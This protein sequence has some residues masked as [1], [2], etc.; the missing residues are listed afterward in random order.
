[1]S[2]G[3]SADFLEGHVGVKLQH[4]YGKGGAIFLTVHEGTQC[5]EVFRIPPC[6]L[7]GK[8]VQGSR[9]PAHVV[10]PVNLF[11]LPLRV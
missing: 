10:G 4:K 6:V 1:M 11:A 8:V 5:M 2:K 3:S 7:G 9:A